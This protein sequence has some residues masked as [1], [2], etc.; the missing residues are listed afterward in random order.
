M[1][2]ER[3]EARYRHICLFGERRIGKDDLGVAD[4]NTKAILD[5]LSGDKL[6]ES[7]SRSRRTVYDYIVCNPF[8]YFCTFT[9]DQAKHD[10]YDYSHCKKVITTFFKNYQQRYAANFKYVI[11]PEAH[12]DDAIHFHGVVRG[13]RQCDF[14]VPE[15]VPKRMDGSNTLTMVPNTRQY[16]DWSQYRRNY[17]WFSCSKIKNQEKCALYV[18]KYITKNLDTM[19]LGQRVVLAS[20]GLY[21]PELIEDISGVSLLFTPEYQNEFCAIQDTNDDLNV[22]PPVWVWDEQSADLHRP[23]PP[24]PT[25]KELEREA[26]EPRLTYDQLM[27]YDVINK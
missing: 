1:Y 16:V 22:V 15:M 5:L 6:Q 4:D 27:M 7:L 24:E 19:P 26:L 12:K 11:V 3:D 13:I 18:S 20:Q 17:G 10:R 9:F 23:L 14:T 8:E 2:R 21:K 25:M